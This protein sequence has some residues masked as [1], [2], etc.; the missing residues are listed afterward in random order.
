MGSVEKWERKGTELRRNVIC[1][2]C[3]QSQRG[4]IRRTSVYQS[5]AKKASVSEMVSD[6]GERGFG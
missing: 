3:C 6:Y 1:P 4:S 5:D 2:P